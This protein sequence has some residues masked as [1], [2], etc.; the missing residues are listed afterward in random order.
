MNWEQQFARTTER[1]RRSAV[2]EFMRYAQRPGMISFGGGLP[3]AELFPIAAFERA[4]KEVLAKRAGSA[5]QYGETE[6]VGELREFIAAENNVAV[7]NVLITSGAQQALDL[8]GRVLIDAD[9]RVAV[10]NPTYLALLSAWRVH[11]PAFEPVRS[12]A[13]GFDVAGMSHGA[14]MLYLV[15]NFQNPQGTTMPLQRREQLAAYAQAEELIV[16]EDDPYG[17]LRYE[18]EA[19]PSIFEL[20]GRCRGPVIKVGTFS[21][22]L[23]PGIRVGWVIADAALIEKLVPAKQAA[24]LHTSTN[25]QQV[26]SELVKSG[27]LREHVPMLCSEYAKR[28]DAML[29]ALKL[30]MPNGVSWTEPAGGM[31][32][33]MTLPESMD[34]TT[35]ARAALKENVLVVP[36]ADFHVVGGENTVRINFSNAKPEWIQI[37]IERLGGVLRTL[38]ESQPNENNRVSFSEVRA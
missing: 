38:L 24:D 20:S 12:D 3:A 7:E 4:T 34:G 22:V 25:N 8:I 1:M 32:L 15:P 17:S 29:C 35:L 6:G 21:K 31:F 5:L 18:G 23:S 16:V 33:L 11:R 37:G 9:D 13:E 14:K 26:A 2:R 36:G 19:L 30:H 27:L 28:R 10:E